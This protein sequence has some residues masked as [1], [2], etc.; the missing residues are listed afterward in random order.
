[1]QVTG[2]RRRNWKDEAT[3]GEAA[4]EVLRTVLDALAP[5]EGRDKGPAA[6]TASGSIWGAD[7]KSAVEHRDSGVQRERSH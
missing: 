4:V 2:S 6:R 1:M 3:A 5:S 7:G